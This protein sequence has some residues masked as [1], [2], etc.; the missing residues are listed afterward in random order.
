MI[1]WYR[2]INLKKEKQQKR[3]KIIH[4]EKEIETRNWKMS[5]CLNVV[6]FN[7][8]EK[9]KKTQFKLDYKITHCE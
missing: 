7:P 6:G 9:E 1:L 5:I 3:E 8:R 4:R 2:L